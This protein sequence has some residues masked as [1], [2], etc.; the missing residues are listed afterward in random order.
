M[1]TILFKRGLEK[2]LPKLTKDGQLLLAMDTGKLYADIPSIDNANIIERIQISGSGELFE[3]PE[4]E[5]I[6]TNTDHIKE[7]ILNDLDYNKDYGFQ[8]E[9][10][11]YSGLIDNDTISDINNFKVQAAIAKANFSSSLIKDDTDK[12][13]KL[14]IEIKGTPPDNN[15]VSFK[16]TVWTL[17]NLN[18][19][20]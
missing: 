10:I 18:K 8:I 3:Y 2:N 4:V 15:L 19:R 11:P 16:L 1:A 17:K 7:Y 20:S 13:I 5:Q 6:F 12:T 9:Y 14:K